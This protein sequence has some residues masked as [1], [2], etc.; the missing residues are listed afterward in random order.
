MPETGTMP[1]L[2]PARERRMTLP[3][4]LS[5]AGFLRHGGVVGLSRHRLAAPF[6]LHWHEFHELT[7]VLDGAGCN[8]MNGQRHAV[9][10]GHAWLCT[11]AD[12]HSLAPEGGATLELCNLLFTEAALPPDLRQLLFGAHGGGA[13]LAHH[14]SL[15]QAELAE[16]AQ[17]I[18]WLER[19]QQG[20]APGRELAMAAELQALLLAWH[21]RRAPAPGGRPARPGHIDAGA[22]DRIHPGIQRALAFV[23]RHFRQPV[24]L[25]DAAAQAH[26]SSAYFSELFHK[27][28]GSTF[29]RHLQ[30]LRLAFAHALLQAGTLPVTEVALAAGFNTVTHFT[31]VYAQA[32]GMP[33]SRAR[34][35][36]RAAP[37]QP[38]P[39]A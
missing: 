29:Q 3:D 20:S 10:A 27:A 21:R 6:R 14:A 32:Y 11:P 5:C 38:P 39:L 26:L 9:H 8:T 24:S 33:P 16:V 1:A 17:R 22:Q 12:F 37:L 15:P 35:A 18:A 23:Q 13:A 2:R 4:R 19:E 25:E 34:G 36:V 7:V 30:G 28:T 31:R